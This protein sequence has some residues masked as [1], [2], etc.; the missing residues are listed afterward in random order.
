M[1]TNGYHLAA[2]LQKSEI[3]DSLTFKLKV[4][5]IDD[6]AKVRRDAV[7]CQLAKACL[8]PQKKQ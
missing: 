4:S 2:T 7:A 8:L 3:S 1:K 6:L 5:D